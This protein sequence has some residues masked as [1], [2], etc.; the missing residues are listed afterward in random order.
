MGHFTTTLH[1]QEAV[2]DWSFCSMR[3]SNPKRVEHPAGRP[4]FWLPTCSHNQQN[5][6][7][8]ASCVMRGLHTLHTCTHNKPCPLASAQHPAHAAHQEL[9]GQ[10]IKE[11]LKKKKKK[12]HDN[13]WIQTLLSRHSGLNTLFVCRML[14][15]SGMLFSPS[16]Q[17]GT[18]CQRTII[19][20]VTAA[21]FQ[22]KGNAQNY[23]GRAWSNLSGSVLCTKKQQHQQ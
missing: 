11:T 16:T 6:G 5:V 20:G 8:V 3:A 21:D 13:I 22:K 12:K 7:G 1:Q 18:T 4:Q 10:K 17:L 2:S 15:Y 9:Q 14:L 19:Q 23:I